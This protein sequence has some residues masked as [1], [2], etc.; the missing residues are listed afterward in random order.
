M[1]DFSLIPLVPSCLFARP[2]KGALRSNER[3]YS[4]ASRV[5]EIAYNGKVKTI[6]NI[7]KL[8]VSHECFRLGWALLFLLF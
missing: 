6:D 5:A 4:L 1:S 3:S 7:H 8:T 2:L